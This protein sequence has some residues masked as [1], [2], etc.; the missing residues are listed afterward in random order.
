[1]EQRLKEVLRKHKAEF[2]TCG[3]A[4]SIGD[5]AW[6]EG[7]TGAGTPCSY[8]SIICPACQRE[9]AWVHSWSWFDEDLTDEERL[10]KVISILENVSGWR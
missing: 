3:Q 2:C 4:V 7:Q 9:V 6:N 8:V 10:D 1:M 5:V